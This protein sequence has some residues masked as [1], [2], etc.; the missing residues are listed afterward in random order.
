METFKLTKTQKGQKFEYVVT[1]NSGNVIS[2]RMSNRDY[3]ACTADGSFYF[4]RLDLIR[5]G[6]HG[7][8][9]SLYMG[10]LANPV[11]NYSFYKKMGGD[12]SI[13]AFEAEER[14][15]AQKHLD[16]LNKIAYL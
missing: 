1:D 15:D 8:M 12:L 13:D 5:K 10:K 4:G 3:V 11:A 14:A 6:D 16:S 2:K 7:R 9:I